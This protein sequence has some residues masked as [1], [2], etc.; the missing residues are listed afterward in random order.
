MPANILI[1]GATGFVGQYLIHYLSEQGYPIVALVRNPPETLPN[2]SNVNIKIIPDIVNCDWSTYLEDVDSVIHC[3]ALAH[4]P[5]VENQKARLW[6]VNVHATEKLA[7]ASQKV[8]VK[9]FIFLSSVKVHGEYT[10]SKP[11]SV[12]DKPFPSDLYGESKWA[13]E[14]AI[15]SIPDL[16]WV[17]IRPPLMYGPNMKGNLD[18]VL[19]ALQ[20]GIY[21]PLKSIRNQRSFLSL[22]NLSH[23]IELCLKH[24]GAV[25]ETFLI[26]DGVD[27]ST[28]ELI[29]AVAAAE[30][31]SPR[32]VPCP[33]VLLHLAGILFKKQ[34]AVAKL[35]QSLQVDI[36]HAANHLNWQ[37]PYTLAQGLEGIDQEIL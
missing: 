33:T 17:I 10:E 3:A 31:L 22:R 32:L 19:K 12:Q 9:R 25:R 4:V 27:L 23:F 28:P 36:S 20:R 6:D 24:P 2:L 18:L 21:L 8:G 35:L 15:R 37:P 26:S 34:D 14:E 13:A 30:G 7:L 5:N 11:F 29:R 16:N 1:T